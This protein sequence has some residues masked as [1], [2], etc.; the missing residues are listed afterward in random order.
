MH[1]G[2]SFTGQA[3]VTQIDGSVYYDEVAEQAK[4]D[5]GTAYDA[6]GRT[7]VTT[8][9]TELGRQTLTPGVYDSA[10]GT[11]GI[12]GTLTLDSEGDPNRV[13]IFK[14]DSTLI[15]AAGSNINLINGARS[16][17]IF[18]Q[19]GSFATLGAN[20]HFVVCPER[21]E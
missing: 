14:I 13:F 20:S 17:R 21:T 19:V 1:P 2:S 16:C 10:D 12:T 3:S 11:L 4:A 6:A 15:T 7:P 5:L 8:I 9:S 18:C